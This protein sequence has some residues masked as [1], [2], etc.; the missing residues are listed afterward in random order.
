MSIIPTLNEKIKNYI[1]YSFLSKPNDDFKNYSNRET[2]ELLSK[3]YLLE[4]NPIKQKEI[5]C[6][7]N[8][9]FEAIISLNLIDTDKQI[10]TLLYNK[11]FNYQNK[12]ISFIELEN[13]IKRINIKDLQ[14]GELSKIF[15]ELNLIYKN[16]WLL[17]N[18]FPLNI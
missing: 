2:L 15:K 3:E 9:I 18:K 11:K 17:I 12:L 1:H 13:K 6:L 4:D 5:E 16:K 8:F 7:F 10:Q 14:N